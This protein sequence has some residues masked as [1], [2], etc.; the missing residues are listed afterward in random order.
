MYIFKIIY[1]LNED[2]ASS[3]SDCQIKND[4]QGALVAQ[5]V[6][7]LTSDFGSSPDLRVL[8]SR[9]K[10]SR[11]SAPP[12]HSAPPSAHSRS[13]ICFLKKGMIIKNFI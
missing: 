5:S 4:P 13:Q 8:G 1:R 3:F 10:L 7:Y 9:H 2:K 12:S 6:K 11:E